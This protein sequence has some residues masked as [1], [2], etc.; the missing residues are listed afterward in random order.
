[1][2]STADVF[3]GLSLPVFCWTG[4]LHEFGALNTTVY[5]VVHVCKLQSEICGAY[6]Y[7]AIEGMDYC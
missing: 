2:S 4:S 1:M 7:D 6:S 5:V 3:S